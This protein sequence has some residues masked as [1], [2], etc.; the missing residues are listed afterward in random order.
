[1]YRESN[2]VDNLD[3]LFGGR[4][5]GSDTESFDWKT[6]LARFLPQW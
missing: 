4:N 3:S 2:V 5:A 6:L 1:M